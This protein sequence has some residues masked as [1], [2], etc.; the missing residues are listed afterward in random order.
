MYKRFDEYEKEI[1]LIKEENE[2]L[3]SGKERVIIVERR[4]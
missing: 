2:L 4:N 1:K 3:R